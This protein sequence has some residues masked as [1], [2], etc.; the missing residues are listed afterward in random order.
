MNSEQELDCHW[1]GH[2]FE[3]T[4]HDVQRATLRRWLVTI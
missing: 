2:D 3:G 4:A 1:T